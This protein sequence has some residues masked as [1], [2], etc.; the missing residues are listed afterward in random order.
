MSDQQNLDSLLKD[1]APEVDNPISGMV[2]LQRGLLDPVS[3][4][5]QTNAEVR[6]LT[7]A[8]EEYLAGLES[9]A[10]TTYAE[11]MTALL[12][13]AVLSV[14]SIDVQEAPDAIDQLILGDRDILFMAIVRCTYGYERE[15]NVKCPTCEEKSDVII[16]VDEDFPIQ[17]TDIDIQSPITTKLRN[18]KEVKF[19][20]PNG[21][22]SSYVAKHGN[23]TATQNTLML[24]RC[25]I[26]NAEDTK[27]K[28]PEVWAKSLNLA[29]RNKLIKAILDIKVGPKMGEVNV[30]CAHCGSN[31]PINITWMSLLFG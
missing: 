26:L 10:S 16:N 6:E 14:G 15:F 4:V 9:K 28:S 21:A 12:R 25:V 17:T 31:M 20:L 11:Y 7:G 19:R 3:G 5:W 1:A 22:D 27:G 2:A 24:S 29:D 18:G 8:D 13:R 23:S 30:Q